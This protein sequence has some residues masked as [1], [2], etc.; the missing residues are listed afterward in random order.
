MS[1]CSWNM[2]RWPFQLVRLRCWMDRSAMQSAKLQYHVSK[3]R[4]NCLRWVWQMPLFLS[5]QY[6]RRLLPSEPMF[7][8]KL[9]KRFHSNGSNRYLFLWMRSWILRSVLRSR[10]LSIE[11][12][13]NAWSMYINLNWS[14][15]PMHARMV[16]EILWNFHT[17]YKLTM[18]ERRPVRWYC[19]RC[20]LYLSN[21][22]LRRT[23]SVFR[24]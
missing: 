6:G 5:N 4:S 17:V 10:G 13:Y 21:R 8:I 14:S 11:L 12:L 2:H 9:R 15:M 1:M 24:L 7:C 16:W 18:S 20:T 23:V 22:I 19:C 3:R